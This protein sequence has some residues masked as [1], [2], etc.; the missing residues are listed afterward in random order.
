MTSVDFKQLDTIHCMDCFALMDALIAAGIQVDGIF[1]DMPYGTTACSWDVRVDLDQ[2]WAAVKRVLKPRGVFLTT[3]SEPF[4]SLLRVSNLDWYKYDWVWEK[5]IAFNFVNAKLK[6][7]SRHEDILVFSPGMTANKN[8]NNMSYYPQGVVYNPKVRS[9]PKKYPTEHRL[10]RPSHKLKRIIEFENY[11]DDILRFSNGN[12]NSTHPT[13]KPV[14]LYEYLIKTYTQPGELVLD[15]F[16]GSGT[17]G[18]AALK[19]GR[20]YILGDSSQEYADLARKRIKNADPFTS[21]EVGNGTKQLSL[22]EM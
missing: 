6:P 20:H 7:L 9:R 21:S 4:A 15:P 16:A 11:P 12:N 10:T 18:L 22:F 17:T 2:W 1:T 8:R 19:T 14:A 13:Q 5:T 3:A